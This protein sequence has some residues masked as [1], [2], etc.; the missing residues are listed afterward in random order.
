MKTIVV[1][2]ASG[3]IGKYLIQ[4]FLDKNINKEYEIIACGTRETR[5]FEIRSIPYY[6]IDITKKELFDYL[7]QKDVYAVVHLA[8]VMPA[9]MHGYNPQKYIDVNITGT[10]N[11]LE[12]CKRACVD[13]ILFSQSFGD[14]R[15]YGE[16]NILINVN[17]ERNFSYSTDHT[18][19]ILTKNFAVDCIRHF[20]A[21]VSLK[22]FVFRLPTIYLYS[23]ID[24][25]YVDGIKKK[26][27]FRSLIDKACR[28][29][30]IEIWGDKNRVKDMVYVKDLCKMLY[31]ALYSD[32]DKGYYNVGTGKGI[33]L[34]D[35]IK[36]IVEVFG[37]GKD[38]KIINR[39]DKPNAPQ[40]VM[41]IKE[42]AEE[43]GYE[44]EDDYIKMLK[45]IRREKKEDDEFGKWSI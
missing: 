20:N 25:Y 8:G 7:P 45:D 22:Y 6:K 24:S 28:G 33:T 19:Y 4:Y 32:R 36:G 15:E 13:R 44:P 35:Q 10:L 38:I 17:M 31:L 40:Y 23:P 26:I 5:F 41:D 18:M 37:D 12:Y 27:G 9:R 34:E 14:L 39:P 3:D 43:L 29:E 30:M 16:K 2:G 1:F 11:I 42:A 21:T